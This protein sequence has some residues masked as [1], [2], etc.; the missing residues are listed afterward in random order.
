MNIKN[1]NFN[2]NID[3][4]KSYSSI[5]Y[6]QIANKNDT[7]SFLGKKQNQPNSLNKNGLST[8]I[9][10][11]LMSP[12]ERKRF[13]DISEIRYKLCLLERDTVDELTKD[14]DS[15]MMTILISELK[16]EDIPCSL[17][18]N[19]FKGQTCQHSLSDSQYYQLKLT[20]DFLKKYPPDKD[21]LKYNIAS[22]FINCGLTLSE[23]DLLFDNYYVQGQEEDIINA[24]DIFSSIKRK[25]PNINN[26]LIFSMD[27]NQLKCFGSCLEDKKFFDIFLNSAENQLKKEKTSKSTYYYGTIYY[28][29]KEISIPKEEIQKEAL[30]QL[31]NFVTEFYDEEQPY[32][33]ETARWCVVNCGKSIEETK[34]LFKKSCGNI[35]KVKYEAQNRHQVT[36]QIINSLFVPSHLTGNEELN[37]ELIDSSTFD[38]YSFSD[39]I[40]I[41]ESAISSGEYDLTDED[42]IAL[43]AECSEKIDKYLDPNTYNYSFA[44]IQNIDFRG[45]KLELFKNRFS[46]LIRIVKENPMNNDETSLNYFNRITTIYNEKQKQISLEKDNKIKENLVFSDV[47]TLATDNKIE[48][49][50]EEKQFLVDVINEERKGL[51]P[52]DIETDMKILANAWVDQY[53]SC[54]ANTPS[55]KYTKIT[56]ACLQELP[57]Y[58]PGSINKDPYA[59]VCRW[60]GFALNDGSYDNFINALPEEGEILNVERI[61]SCSKNLTYAE[62]EFR[63]N[64]SGKNVK[65]IIYPKS[66][67]SK[68][69][70][71]GRRKYGD[72]E[73]IYPADTK[74][75]VLHKGIEEYELK[76]Y[77]RN[78]SG[79]IARYYVYLQEV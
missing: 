37:K 9:R 77:N 6:T 44:Y 67:V 47:D 48:L 26:D 61:Q 59:P 30:N 62:N 18:H 43:F 34:E 54:Y 69:V 79:S 76:N 23:T 25:Y 15:K 27:V 65:Y 4:K 31:K 8:V 35:N 2:S 49:T 74:F 32:K 3:N 11:T 42:L 56:N 1:K 45:L 70:D 68:A 63:D 21:H 24:S 58:V 71:I 66:K 14:F 20:V 39:V 5:I 64:N 7:V 40:N 33:F 57:K 60:M 75:K 41:I 10:Y 28:E 38:S 46:D 72:N 22:N 36:E 52:Y 53:I 19:T 12:E 55:A 51:E 17:Y 78:S 29:S 50:T 13:D 73:V 16:K